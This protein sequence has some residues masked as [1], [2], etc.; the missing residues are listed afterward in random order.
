MNLSNPSNYAKIS[1]HANMSVIEVDKPF[2]TMI[3]LC[4]LI[5]DIP[6]QT[7]IGYLADTDSRPIRFRCISN[8]PHNISNYFSHFD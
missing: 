5:L 2:S 7:S 8:T 1:F 3:P 4:Y 6:H